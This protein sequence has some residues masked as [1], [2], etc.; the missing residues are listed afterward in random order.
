MAAKKKSTQKNKFAG[1]FDAFSQIIAGFIEQK[2]KIKKRVEDIRNAVLDALYAFKAQ[3]FRS[4]VEGFLLLT[5]IAAL[6]IGS[7]MFLSKYISIDVLLL[8]YGIIISFGVLFIAKLK[9]K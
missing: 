5:G 3:L 9:R 6:V 7:I 2:L 1:Y 8:A 4:V